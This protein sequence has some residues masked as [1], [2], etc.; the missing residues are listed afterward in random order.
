MS[1]PL[2]DLDAFHKHITDW[3]EGLGREFTDPR[4]D[5]PLVAQIVTPT[6]DLVVAEIDVSDGKDV[7]AYQQLPKMILGT[8]ATMMGL[9]M[10]AWRAPEPPDGSF[11]PPSM[12]EDRVEIV[13]VTSMSADRLIS[14]DAEIHRTDDAP[15]TLG[16]WVLHSTED[17]AAMTGRF[18]EP[19]QAALR[20]AKG[21][22]PDYR[23]M[24]RI[25]KANKLQGGV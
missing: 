13:M 9:V 11:L 19:S 16:E 15:P 1:D 4:D 3:V 7:V 6:N 21:R 17:G 25:Q 2:R 12:R 24:S 23:V 20:K 8:A 22:M 5:W 10:S 14:A 18:I